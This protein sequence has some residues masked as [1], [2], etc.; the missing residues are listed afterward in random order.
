MKKTHLPNLIVIGSI[1][2]LLLSG[3]KIIPIELSPIEA[4]AVIFSGWC[5][6]LLANN[7][8]LGWWV[9]LLGTITYM[10]VFYQAKLY[11]DVLL[12]VFFLITSIEAIYIWWRGG[13]NHREKMI[14][15]ISPRWHILTAILGIISIF[16]LQAILIAMGGAAPFWD[17]LAT[18]LSAIA[19]IYLMLRDVESWYLWITVDIIYI[20]LYASQGLYLTTILH[21]YFLLMAIQGLQN[22]KRIYLEQQLSEK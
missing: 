11:G 17:A 6:W 1:F 13:K 8:P 22:F 12:Q 7:N 18:V 4:I 2:L 9:G 10:I 20:P 3:P 15:Y 14:G 21:G 5:V 19:Q 16:A